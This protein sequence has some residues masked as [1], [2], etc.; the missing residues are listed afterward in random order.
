[1]KMTATFKPKSWYIQLIHIAKSQLAIDDETYRASLKSITGQP[2]CSKMS[3]AELSQV[4]EFMKSKGFKAKAKKAFSPKTSDKNSHTQLDK[5]RQLWIQMSHQGL[6]NDGSEQALT[7][8][9]A[10]QSKSLNNGVP[11]AKLEWLKGNMLY[12]LIEQLK[13]WHLRVL[14]EMLPE[15]YQLVT[16]FN[17]EDRLDDTCRASFLN[18]VHRLGKSQTHETVNSAYI[19]CCQ[20]LEQINQQQETK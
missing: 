3:I 9:A 15:K 4:L 10:S 16:Q 5:L 6:L 14:K 13:G 17:Q 11:I 7:K 20:I 8:W 19:T 12:A 18:M 2:S 1:M